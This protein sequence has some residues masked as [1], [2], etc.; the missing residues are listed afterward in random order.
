MGNKIEF[1]DLTYPASRKELGSMFPPI[2]RLHAIVVPPEAFPIYTNH[3]FVFRTPAEFVVQTCHPI[4]P[5]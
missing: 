2:L 3:L 1:D 5:N 4:F